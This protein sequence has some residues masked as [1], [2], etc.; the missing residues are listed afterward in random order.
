MKHI[1]LLLLLVLS[2]PV[3]SQSKIEKTVVFDFTKPT[4]LSPSKPDVDKIYTAYNVTDET[5]TADN[6]KIHFY[7]SEPGAQSVAIGTLD[8]V[9]SVL[10]FFKEGRMEV[11][12]EVDPIV[13]IEFEGMN[14]LG[15]EEGP[16]TSYM[17]NVWS[18]SEDLYTKPQYSVKFRGSAEYS[19]LSR[20]K[21]TYVVTQDIL[22]PVRTTFNANDEVAAFN[23]YKMTF[24][25][26]IIV[27][28]DASYTVNGS[29]GTVYPL[30]VSLDGRDV[31]LTSETEINEPGRYSLIVP[32]QSINSVDNVYYNKEYNIP[33]V[34]RVPDNAF[35][36]AAVVP[37][38]GVVDEIPN[39]ITLK[40]IGTVGGVNTKVQAILREEI[41][42]TVKAKYDAEL[43]D[44]NDKVVLKTRAKE[45]NKGKYT[46]EIPEKMVYNIEFKNDEDDFGVAS[47]EAKYNPLTLVHYYIG[48]DPDP[49]PEPEPEPEKPAASDAV[50][51]KADALL[52]FSGVGYPSTVS[53]ARQAISDL[54]EDIHST[55]EQYNEAFKAFYASTEI[56]LPT[57]GKTYHIANVAL[58][59]TKSYLKYDGD[60]VVLTKDEVQAYCFEAEVDKSKVLFKTEDGKYL[61]TLTGSNLYTGTSSKNITSTKSEVNEL[62]ISRFE[63]DDVDPEKVFGYVSIYGT[64]GKRGGNEMFTYAYVMTKTNTF[65]APLE[66]LY[67]DD[68]TSSAFVMEEAERPEVPF[69]TPYTLNITPGSVVDVLE[70][71]VI[72]FP[73][74]A[75]VTYT[76]SPSIALHRGQ[77]VTEPISVTNKSEN[78]ISIKFKNV[79]QGTYFLKASRG[80]FMAGEKSIQDI[81]IEYTVRGPEFKK[82]YA[83]TCTL[84]N[85][86]NKDGRVFFYSEDLNDYK[87][88]DYSWLNNKPVIADKVI[89]LLDLDANLARVATA[90]LVA[91]TIVVTHETSDTTS[92]T[93]IYPA[94]KVEFDH[95]F[96]R[97]ELISKTSYARTLEIVI[98]EG[99]FGDANFGKYINDPMSVD[100][101]KCR[102]NDKK[103]YVV[104]IYRSPDPEDPPVGPVNPEDP[105]DNPDDPTDDPDNPSVDPDDPPVEPVDP[106]VVDPLASDSI[107]SAAKTLLN[108]TGIGYPSAKSDARV[109]LQELLVKESATEKEYE[110][111][112]DAFCMSTEIA[113]PED[114]KTYII[115]NVAKSGSVLYLGYKN[116]IIG[117]TDKPNEA[118]RFEV[119]ANGEAIVFKFDKN[120]YLHGLTNTNENIGASIA[121][122]T[123]NM[124]MTN[125]INVE[126]LVVSSLSPV[127]AMG[128]VSLYGFV[129]VKDSKMKYSYSLV[130]TKNG[131]IALD[132]DGKKYFDD[133]YSSAFRIIETTPAPAEPFETPL[134][135]S[136]QGDV[137]V[138]EEIV[139]TFPELEGDVVYTAKPEIVLTSADGKTI[140]PAV[141][142]DKNVV[143]IKFVNVDAG[144]YTLDVPF[145]ALV[146]GADTI[147]A[148]SLKYQVMWGAEFVTDFAKGCKYQVSVVSDEDDSTIYTASL[149]NIRLYDEA[150]NDSNITLANK[151][152]ELTDAS[153]NVIATGK[154]TTSKVYLEDE[155][156]DRQKFFALRVA[157]DTFFDEGDIATGDYTLVI[158]EGAIGDANYGKYLKDASS[159]SKADC[160]VNAKQNIKL[161]IVSESETQISIKDILDYID[162][163]LNQ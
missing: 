95:V 74:V 162:K 87:I 119:I 153:G 80:A 128:Y 78:S 97:N 121:N 22:S 136:G 129:G 55:D 109:A 133:E 47:S 146:C 99:T 13:K 132:L 83:N 100:K 147:Q 6:I 127:E 24:D 50:L 111:A 152:V 54:K 39:E 161:T 81:N 131:E 148:I 92:A 77:V 159:I 157:F 10:Q 86:A 110:D 3:F 25:K 4:T 96:D 63:C 31:T 94:L 139:I 150:W 68:E 88:V 29:D 41:S 85:P 138:L 34:V 116:G 113:K 84:V 21:V 5:F 26:D 158:P 12:S 163:Y 104:N 37:D 102:V 19:Y 142:T 8:V 48:I 38:S 107:I 155:S 35:K 46:L 18:W 73:Q 70:E 49:E 145:G 140:K 71:I 67:F 79:E 59:G 60:A 75:K 7:S 30:I 44:E 2:I 58:D 156:G 126:K 20:I 112:I 56:E 16:S 120:K 89:E 118:C 124:S 141:S 9:S 62:M 36:I 69:E 40:L 27:D 15:L 51:A 53:S 137:D 114:G 43:T 105:S 115:S 64:L 1:F 108:L 76:G 154:L 144:A 134:E 72:T 11:Y 82:D 93:I 106:P 66:G 135:V 122:Y 42:N 23:S 98:P 14:S 52:A 61:H 28:P 160:H 17:L 65:D 117:L 101:T 151:S 91:D 130:N 103:I 143:S 123:V 125:D 90:R 57:P 33:F 32:A 45:T 149:N